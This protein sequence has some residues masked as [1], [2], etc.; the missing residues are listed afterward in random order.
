MYPSPEQFTQKGFYAMFRYSNTLGSLWRTAAATLTVCTGLALAA[1]TSVA[2]ASPV[3]AQGTGLICAATYTVKPGDDL[4]RIAQANGTNWPTLQQLNGI[5]N[6]NLLFVGQ[7][8]C[9]PNNILVV[10]PIAT[11]IPVITTT[12]A[13]ISTPILVTATPG[14]VSVGGLVLPPPGV[15]PSIAFDR[16]FAV[17]GDTITITGVNFPT[18]GIADVFI[19]PLTSPEAYMVAAQTTTSATGTVNFAFTIPTVISGQTL[20]GYAFSVLVKERIT[21]YYGFSFFYNGVPH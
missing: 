6:P 18:N 13:P 21:G 19:K 20:S 2:A 7:N 12:P 3:A 11:V 17:P 16:Q 1:V 8:I 4:Y 15:F 9:L 14:A 10:T 5:A